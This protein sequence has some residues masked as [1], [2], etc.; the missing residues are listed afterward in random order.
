GG[1]WVGLKWPPGDSNEGGSHLPTVWKW[2][3]CSPGGNPLRESLSRTPAGVCD[4]ETV[5]TPCPFVSLSAAFADCATAGTA[6]AIVSRVVAPIPEECFN[7]SRRG[8]R[9]LGGDVK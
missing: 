6:K 2:K 3:A 4:S 8:E 5:P 1:V 7:F 9:R